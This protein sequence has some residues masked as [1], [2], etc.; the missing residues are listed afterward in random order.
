MTIATLA[1][2]T[3]KIAFYVLLSLIVGRAMGSPEIWMDRDWISRIGLF[4]Y[5]PGETGADNIYDLYFYISVITIFSVTTVIYV[6]AMWLL[7]KIRG[8]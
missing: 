7:K 8:R 1:R 2:K 4:L 5:G 3:V 6:F